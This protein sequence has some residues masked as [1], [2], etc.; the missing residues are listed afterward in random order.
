M[1]VPPRG[2]LIRS[3]LLSA[4]GQGV[5]RRYGIKD[6]PLGTPEAERHVLYEVLIASDVNWKK[7]TLAEF[8]N[9]YQSEQ[10]P[11]TY[12]SPESILRDHEN[13]TISY[14]NTKLT[15]WRGDITKLKVGAI[16]N[17]ANEQ[18]LGC[19]IPNHRCIDNVIHREAGPRLRMACREC[20]KQRGSPLAAGTPPI[21]TPAFYLPSEYVIHV[22]GPQIRN[23][24]NVSSQDESNLASAYWL[25]L[26]AALSIGAKSIAFPCI[27]TGVFGFPQD[28]AAHIALQT[29]QKWV[30]EHPGMID[31]VIFDVFT[32]TDTQLYESG[33]KTLLVQEVDTSRENGKAIVPD[34]FTIPEKMKLIAKRWIDDADAVLICAGAGM[35]VKEGEM[36][37]TNKYDFAT[38]YPYVTKW[39]YRTGYEAMGLL[40]DP[41]V[42]ITAKWAFWAKHMDDLRR[43]FEPNEGY[44]YIRGLVD[45]KEH[46]ILTSNI[47]GCFERSGFDP[48]KIYTPQGDF[49]YLQCMR[50][51][52]PDSVFEGSPYLDELV[53]AITEDGHIPEDLVPRCPRC[54]SDMFGNVRGGSWFLHHKYADGNKA[55]IQW[56]EDQKGKKVVAVEVGAGF[57]TPMVTR[58]PVESFVK[59]IHGKLIRINPSDPEIPSDVEGLSFAEGWELL[60]E[61]L[62]TDSVPSKESY[63]EMLRQVREFLEEEGR[64]VPAAQA[65]KIHSYMGHFNWKEFLQN[66][67]R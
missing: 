21:I 43:K 41:K 10:D 2:N 4:L 23:L 28:K 60:G 18:G 26:D 32:D 53:P 45:Q 39:G 63:D 8:D 29:V 17:A 22:T 59:A 67:S 65:K 46:F 31:T 13:V 20:M 49:G 24:M 55:I 56:M 33:L 48:K 54:G 61:I 35:S 51:C 34:A 3:A 58:W 57:N 66:L 1:K 62:Q 12:V 25:S 16:V 15:V 30:N 40:R 42:P 44:Q 5:H 27:S 37:F 6:I 38:H 52:Q 9:L 19:F 47:D 7:D 50:P 64:V 36:V 14:R 11:E